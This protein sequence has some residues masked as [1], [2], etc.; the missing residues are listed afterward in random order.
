M[1]QINGRVA[2]VSELYGEKSTEMKLVSYLLTLIIPG[3]RSNVAQAVLILL[4][5]LA[6]A[7]WVVYIPLWTCLIRWIIM[8]HTQERQEAALGLALCQW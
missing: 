7:V 4:L 2:S 1:R 3:L 6:K 8:N 5:L